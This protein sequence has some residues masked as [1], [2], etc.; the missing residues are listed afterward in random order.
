MKL[1]GMFTEI[2]T[3]TRRFGLKIKSRDIRL[4]STFRSHHYLKMRATNLLEK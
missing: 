2:Q 4:K 1:K 3:N